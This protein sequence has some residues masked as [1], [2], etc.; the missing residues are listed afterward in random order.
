VSTPPAS[1]PRRVTILGATGSI[2]QSALRVIRAYPER[3]EVVAL[4]AHANAELLAQQI[5]EFRP[6]YA[7]I[8]SDNANGDIPPPPGVEMFHGRDALARIAGIDVDVLLCAVVGAVGL[9]AILAAIGA[10]NTVALANKEPLI[11]AGKL[12]THRA[13]DAGV[14]LLPVDSEHNAIFQCLEGHDL[15]DIR[16]VYL[17]ASG[18]PFYRTPRESLRDVSPKQAAN[19]PTWDMGEKISVD[20]ATLMNKGLEIIEAM[21]LFDLPLDKLQVVIHPQSVVHALIEFHDGNLLAH[22]G[23]TDMAMPIQFAFTWP[24]R[25]KSPLARL[26]LTDL[27]AITFDTPDFDAFPCLNL[28]LDAARRGGT[29]GAVLNAANETAVN[30]FREHRL[31]FL[32]IA[33]IVGDVMS[34]THFAPDYD[35]HDILEVDREARARAEALIPR[36]RQRHNE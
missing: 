8:T 24:Q 36:A 6:R 31:P 26:E 33:E 25:V 20:S 5:A 2:G 11:M 7:A 3:F 13:R 17:T 34:A 12:I 28:A 10:G 1:P 18:G 35:L 4:T 30:A 21:W 27:S 19:H 22:L 15:D 32:G 16:T 14:P 29:A 9:E 23:A